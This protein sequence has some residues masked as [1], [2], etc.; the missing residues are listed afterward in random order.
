[1]SISTSDNREP[2][3]LVDLPAQ[4]SREK[5][6]RQGYTMMIDW[7]IAL[8][9]QRDLLEM[10]GRY[11]DLAKIAVGTSRFYDESYLRAKLDLYREHQVR[12]FLGGQFQEFIFA[13]KGKNALRPFL[14]EA[15]RL[16]FE[17]VEVSDNCIP[18]SPDDRREMIELA[19]DVGLQVLGEVGSKSDQTSVDV[20]IEQAELAFDSG[21]ELVLVEGAELIDGG[22]IKSDM[23]SAL[24]RN[25]DM[26]RVLFELPGPWVSGTSLSEIH[27][28][29]KTLIRE[30]GADVNI[31]NVIPDD[32]LETEAL[33]CGLGVVGPK[34]G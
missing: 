6:R 16:G 29:K 33:R 21:A 25:L 11:V 34:A 2:F 22:V 5:P 31:A 13:T 17:V 1:M 7:G 28:L 9:R 12:P 10:A 18:L 8:G 27:D 30:F 4:R 15:R 14:E 24:K 3:A 19:V 32:V 20:L 26:T 23:L